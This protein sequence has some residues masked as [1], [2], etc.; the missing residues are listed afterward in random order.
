MKINVRT[1]I[2]PIS[3]RALDDEPYSSNTDIEC[4]ERV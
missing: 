2:K 3:S 4:D 1:L